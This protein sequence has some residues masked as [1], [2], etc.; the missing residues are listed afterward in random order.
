MSCIAMGLAGWDVSVDGE[1]SDPSSLNTWLRENKGYYDDNVL[2]NDALNGLVPNMWSQAGY[3]DNNIPVDDLEEY[4]G[5]GKHIMIAN[6]KKGE[7]HMVLATAYDGWDTITV[8]DPGFRTTQYSYS[9]DI[10]GWRL[11]KMSD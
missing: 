5:R 7:G 2:V 8:N 3:F 10:W 9:Q 11:F 6:V 1:P 4:F